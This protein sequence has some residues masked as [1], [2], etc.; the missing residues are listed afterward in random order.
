[1]LKFSKVFFTDINLYSPSG[2]LIAS[3][4]PEIFNL[5]LLSEN[6]NPMAYEEIMVKSRLFYFTQEKIG[7]VSY[8]SSYAPLELGGDNTAGIVNL[9]YFA[10]Q[11]E[12]KQAYYL[13]I[14]T[15]INLF[16]F[17]GIIGTV[18]AVAF[19]RIITRPL[20]VLQENIADRKSTRLNS[21]HT[22]ISRM[23]SSA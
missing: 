2:Q 23:P 16:V 7:K 5:G 18:I 10:K 4:R 17:L 3:S 11:T 21:S 22:D 14:F 20:K 13:M 19:S 12:V 15:F 1:M 6:I 8:Y 9:P